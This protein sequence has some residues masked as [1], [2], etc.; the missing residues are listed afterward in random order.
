MPDQIKEDK[1][2]GK[3]NYF[4]EAREQKSYKMQGVWLRM[5]WLMDK[6]DSRRNV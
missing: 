1:I 4:D 3:S 5:L 6:D 2:V